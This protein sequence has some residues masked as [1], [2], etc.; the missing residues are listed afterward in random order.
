MTHAIVGKQLCGNEVLN[1]Q[2][3]QLPQPPSD[4]VHIRHTARG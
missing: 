1:W 4:E 2:E 3:T